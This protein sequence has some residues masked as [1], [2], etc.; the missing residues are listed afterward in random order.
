MKEIKEC[1]YYFLNKKTRNNKPF[2]FFVVA[3]FLSAFCFDVVLI[4]PLPL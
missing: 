2:Q 4:L 3:L 1:Y